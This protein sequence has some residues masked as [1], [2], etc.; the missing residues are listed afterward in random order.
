MRLNP[1]VYYLFPAFP[2]LLAA[3]SVMWECWCGHSSLRWVKPAYAT[4]LVLLGVAL[5]PLAI[6]VLPVET[7]VRYS[8]VTGI[9]QPRVETHRL[10]PLPQLFADQFGCCDSDSKIARRG[11]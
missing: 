4:L 6:P 11:R 5:A 10:G 3:G 7:L 8:E 9:R 2:V 1:R